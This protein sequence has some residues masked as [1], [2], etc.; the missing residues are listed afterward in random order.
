[1]LANERD[2]FAEDNLRRV[3]PGRLAP[4]ANLP[5]QLRR[6]S[7]SAKSLERTVR[8]SFLF[9]L[10]RRIRQLFWFLYAPT[11]GSPSSY[12]DLDAVLLLAG[13]GMTM[14]LHVSIIPWPFTI[15]N[16]GSQ[17]AVVSRRLSL[18]D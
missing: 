3:W 13:E 2:P 10:S 7:A 12:S 16:C 1:M 11:D 9:Y 14:R 15:T 6:L 8:R 17:L 4:A 5:G 18:K